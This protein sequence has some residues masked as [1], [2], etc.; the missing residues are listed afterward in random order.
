MGKII[1]IIVPVLNEAALIT[2]TLSALQPLRA[3]G[4]EVIVA[5]GGSADDTRALAESLSDRLIRSPCGRSRQMNAGARLASGEI[6]LFLH[7]DTFLPKD[8]DQLIIG[9]MNLK[10]CRWGR[11]DV[12]LSGNHFLFRIIERS[13][14]WRS[15]LTGITTGDQGIF[16]Q[17][18]LFET[19]GG[20][21]EIDLMEDIALSKILKRYDRPVCLRQPVLTSSRRWEERGVL[22]TILLMWRLRL[23]YLLGSNS[24]RLAHI[25]ERPKS[26]L[27]SRKRD[28]LRG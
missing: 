8:A 15:R 23:L 16:V 19:V 21:P 2:Q 11:F 9:A 18:Q 28:D 12:R 25:Y 24:K 10:K 3:T 22:R 17:R 1:S 13:M 27:P 5:D 14:N 26:Q 7:V 20:F 6:L 4:H